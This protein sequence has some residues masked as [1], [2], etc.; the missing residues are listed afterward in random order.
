MI[1]KWNKLPS[2]MQFGLLAIASLVMLDVF[3][4]ASFKVF[5]WIFMQP[6]GEEMSEKQKKELNRICPMC[7]MKCSYA[8]DTCPSCEVDLRIEARAKG[9]LKK[10]P[11]CELLYDENDNF[12]SKCGVTLVRVKKTEP[13]MKQL[14]QQEEADG[15]QASTL[16]EMP[17]QGDGKGFPVC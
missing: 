9:A 17:V 1:E 3:V 15:E 8:D 11:T 13:H 6:Q 14:G 5:C 7:F 2:F 16:F 12:C 4:I 10:C